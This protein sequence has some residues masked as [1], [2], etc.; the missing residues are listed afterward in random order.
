MARGMRVL[1]ERLG[2]EAVAEFQGFVDEAG[3][4]WRDDVMAVAAERFERRLG[5]E[6]GALRLDMVQGLAAVRVDMA[7][8][9]SA[10]RTDMTRELSTVRLEM[11]TGFAETRTDLLKWSF[12]F[13]IGQFAALSGMMAFLLRT[14]R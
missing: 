7:R 13:W 3:Q 9:F 12:L 10:V 11:A 2:D 6:A 14:I 8:E 1:R 4:K 5:A